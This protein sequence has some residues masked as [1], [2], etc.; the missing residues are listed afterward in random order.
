MV[1]PRPH[2]GSAYHPGLLMVRLKP[3][4]ELEGSLWASRFSG[5]AANS[6][7]HFERAGL[8]RSVERLD[9]DE[10][11]QPLF[12][13]SGADVTNALFSTRAGHAGESDD[14]LANLAMIEFDPS[15]P[16]GPLMLEIA[17]DPRVLRVS[18]V[19]IR[20][21]IG[22]AAI[23]GA[24]SMAAAWWNLTKIKWGEARAALNFVEA[25]AITVAV[26]D[27]GIDARHPD[28][29]ERVDGYWCPKH[30]S[31]KDIVGHGTHVAGIIAAQ[32]GNDIGIEGICECK[33][34]PYK[35]FDDQPSYYEETDRFEFLVNPKSYLRALRQC[36]FDSVQVINLS[37][38]GYELDP[39]EAHVV[40]EL[41][42]S[43]RVVVAGMGND[44]KGASRIAYPAAL[45]EVVAV[46]AT[47][48]DDSR[49]Q[50]SSRGSHMAICAPGDWIWSTLPTYPGFRYYEAVFDD[51]MRPHPGAAESRKENYYYE[52]GT[53]MAAAHVSA[54]VALV[55]AQDP[56]L[57][58]QDVRRKLMETA[59]KVPQMAA[60]SFTP[61]HGA[62]R[63][64]LASLLARP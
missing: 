42:R 48:G 18:Q 8:V 24:A 15:Q 31:E 34:R 13:A 2:R 47:T 16:L 27:T 39:E 3:L 23:G 62:G 19:P 5:P 49:L 54:A 35:V 52:R 20:H 43:R 60:E 32:I 38:A 33:L 4:A 41:I 1:I 50:S 59:E 45:D 14:P 51:G 21:L 58:P 29:R 53:S 64:A 12:R 22:G 28:L 56:D 25:S 17:R 7:A 44:G 63:L 6:L 61:E 36:K 46:G 30:V 9:M 55:L 26:L 10:E 11:M 57:S 37:L 40:S